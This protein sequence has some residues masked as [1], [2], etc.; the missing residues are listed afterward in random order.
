MMIMKLSAYSRLEREGSDMIE[1]PLCS[2]KFFQYFL[3]LC[4]GML[5]LICSLFMLLHF[6]HWYSFPCITSIEFYI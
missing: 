5:Y 1:P 2:S 4:N 3:L 6:F